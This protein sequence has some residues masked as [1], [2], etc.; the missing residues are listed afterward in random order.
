MA[1]G[2]GSRLWPLST[3]EN[4]KQFIPL[5]D[6]SFSLFQG[7]LKKLSVFDCDFLIIANRSNHLLV[8]EQVEDLNLS[9][10]YHFLFEDE[11]RNTFVTIVLAAFFAKHNG[12]DSIIAFPSDQE[13][14]QDCVL[15]IK[16]NLG[17]F[18][19]VTIFGIEPSDASELYGYIEV[20]NSVNC[21]LKNV[22][23]FHEK[24][25]KDVAQQYYNNSSF[26]WN[27]GV[28]FAEVDFLLSY[29]AKH[30][31]SKMEHLLSLYNF[32][33]VDFC[34]S[35]NFRYDFDFK[36]F[37][38]VV[39]E[40]M[41]EC[42]HCFVL[43]NVQLK[44]YGSWGKVCDVLKKDE[45]NNLIFGKKITTLEVNSSVVVNYANGI[46]LYCSHFENVFVCVTDNVVVVANRNNI[47]NVLSKFRNSYH[48]HN[49]NSR[50]GNVVFRKWGYY[51]VLMN[52][53]LIKLKKLVLNPNQQTSLQMHFL[54]SEYWIVVTGV[55]MV[56]VDGVSKLLYAGESVYIPKLSHHQIVN[57]SPHQCLVIIEMQYGDN[58]EDDIVRIS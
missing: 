29:L 46:D 10:K 21:L 19:N 17:A 49:N 42:L 28:V 12:Y 51:E 57:C 34:G 2:L 18:K 44:D 27:L 8:K 4:P 23:K 30:Y 39:L 16:S 26:Y 35:S 11:R 9:T 14:D 32:L 31:S 54:R 24:P 1:G 15:Q 33:M 7:V 36:S 43:K 50:N 38:Y 25:R 47:D 22:V 40:K 45:R 53:E 55:A 58:N 52:K 6:N 41:L 5:F 48:N 20:N 56:A 3:N 13:L 37:D